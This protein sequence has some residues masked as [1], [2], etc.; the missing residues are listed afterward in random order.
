MIRGRSRGG[1]PFFGGALI[2]HE[3]NLVA[4]YAACSFYLNMERLLGLHR[5]ALLI[6]RF[7][8]SFR[9]CGYLPS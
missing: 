9:V 3:L 4:V 2:R 1:G 6:H 7:A 8:G 5:A